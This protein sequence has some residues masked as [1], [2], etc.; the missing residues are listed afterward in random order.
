MSEEG[1]IVNLAVADTDFDYMPDEKMNLRKKLRAVNIK[2]AKPFIR[3]YDSA[4]LSPDSRY[5]STAG[6]VPYCNRGGAFNHRK[7]TI[8]DTKAGGGRDQHARF[9]VELMSP[10]ASRAGTQGITSV[11]NRCISHQNKQKVKYH[12]AKLSPINQKMLK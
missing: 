11:S 1:G 2:R 10:F 9:L 5:L 12:V 7:G 4:R 6:T 3:E 8:D